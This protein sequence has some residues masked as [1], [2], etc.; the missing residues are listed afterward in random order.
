MFSSVTLLD[1]HQIM[2]FVLRRS[3]NGSSIGTTGYGTK[4]QVK[5]LV[6]PWS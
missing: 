1:G 2:A 5:R 6:F 4:E 3:K